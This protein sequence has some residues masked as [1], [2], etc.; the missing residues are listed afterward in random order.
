MLTTLRDDFAAE[1]KV[2]PDWEIRP[3][4]TID[5]YL[6]TAATPSLDAGGVPVGYYGIKAEA[7]IAE[8]GVMLELS[9][10]CSYID[11]NSTLAGKSTELRKENLLLILLTLDTQW[12]KDKMYAMAGQ[13]HVAFDTQRS[14][15]WFQNN[16]QT[17]P[18]S[19]YVR[20]WNGLQGS[21]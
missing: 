15:E 14:R 13:K 21:D 2:L 10:E 18:G 20:K 6:A 12:S 1:A 11:P 19:V 5:D 3:D 4:G 7:S 8:G 17:V 9:V 16:W